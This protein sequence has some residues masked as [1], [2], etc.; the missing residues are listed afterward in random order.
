MTAS[1]IEGLPEGN[2]REEEE[3]IALNCSGV[4]FAGKG[5]ISSSIIG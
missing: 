3:T 2:S 4:A 5:G 1:L